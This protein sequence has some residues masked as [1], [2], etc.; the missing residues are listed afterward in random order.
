M[1]NRAEESCFAKSAF[2]LGC[3]ACGRSGKCAINE[4][5]FMKPLVGTRYY[6]EGGVEVLIFDGPRD[7]FNISD[8]G[9]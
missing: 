5:A 6:K 9:I 7:M 1:K 2:S 8:E 4:H 3:D